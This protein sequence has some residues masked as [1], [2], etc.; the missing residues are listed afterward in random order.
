MR[1]LIVASI[2]VGV[3]AYGVFAYAQMSSTNFRIDWDTISSGGRD[4]STSGS[5]L[6]RDTI[7]NA[8]IGQGTSATYL[9]RSGYRQ[10]IGDEIIDFTV[11]AQLNSSKRTA[12]ALLG[13]TITTS[14][15]SLSIGDL[16]A[17][18][19]DEGAAQVSAIGKIVSIGVGTIT[20]DELKDAGV[21]PTIDGTNDFVY[22]ISSGTANFGELD[23]AE[24][25]TV[26]IAF[27]VNADVDGGYV[28]QVFS[29][30]ELDSGVNDINSVGD[31]TVTTGSEEYGARSSDTT[32]T[33]STF[34]TADSAF[35]SSFQDIADESTESFESRNFLTLKAS[36]D[37]TTVD[38]NYTQ[39]LTFIVSGNF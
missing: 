1:L 22:R 29:D 5:Y 28:V 26:I 39:T 31:G 37:G 18:V 23:P 12:T 17:L 4:D 27:I 34:D 35:T 13:T 6:L 36:I 19:Q 14:T 30:G 38:A 9:L 7:G 3:F 25:N 32:L 21:A 24:F 10:G 33:A 16:V 11:R 2:V 15:S 20:L 8:A